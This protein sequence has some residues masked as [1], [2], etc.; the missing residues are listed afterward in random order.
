MG[1]EI[2]MVIVF[3]VGYL[4]IA[5]EHNIH[6]DKA[7]SA[8]LIGMVSWGLYALWPA[9]HLKV[10]T[11]KSISELIQDEELRENHSGFVEY[12][13]VEQDKNEKAALSQE[14]VVDHASDAGH[15]D[16]GEYVQHFVEHG[17]VHHLFDIASILF[18]LLGAMTIVELIDAHDGFSIITD[19]IRTT[20]KVKLLWVICILT[21]FMSAALDNL[22]TSIVM[23]SVIRKLIKNV[24]VRWLFGGFIIIAANAGGAWSPIGDVTT[25][26]LWN[27]GQLPS[28]MIIVTELIIPSLVAMIVPLL[29]ASFFIKGSVER[30]EKVEG[31]G[32]DVASAQSWEKNLVFFVGLA[33]LLF[34]PVFK[35]ATHL[36]PFTGMMLSLGF[37]WMITELLHAKKKSEDKKGLSVVSVLQ[38]IDTASVLFFLGILMAVAALQEV[39]HLAQVAMFL[40][41][42]LDQN[43]YS[44]N[45]AIGLLSAVVDNV[46]LVA[47]AQGMYPVGVGNFAENGMF[48]Q[49]LAYCA[50]TG[51]SALII[52]SAA[53]VAVMGL[54]KISFG[55]YIKKISLY[56][57]VGYFAGALTYYLMNAL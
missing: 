47:A 43:L 31:I 33:G 8:L 42:T 32:H 36:P 16:T 3:V 11:S 55:W 38:K 44:I 1:I 6:V 57:I 24:E 2:I 35:T 5:L 52:G 20:N 26:M 18:F 22:T 30:P 21:F 9:E 10:D 40:D 7:A 46:P 28:T 39:G 49:F 29:I 12:L 41:D 27:N 14:A 54:E 56:A 19:K 15:H 50:G 4:A 48:W 37:L 25:T 13:E 51:G 45:I 17:L 23:I 34:V 53:G